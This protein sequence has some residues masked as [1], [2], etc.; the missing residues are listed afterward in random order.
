ME[1]EDDK[2][3]LM[4][5]RYLREIPNIQYNIFVIRI[6][7]GYGRASRFKHIDLRLNSV[8]SQVVKVLFSSELQYI[9][10]PPAFPKL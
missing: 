5:Y 6:K 9:L 3:D 7:A 2:L 8:A 1:E 10:P 4:L